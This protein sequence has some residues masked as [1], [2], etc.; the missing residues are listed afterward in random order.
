MV[1]TNRARYAMINA[2][3]V[4]PTVSFSDRV[5]SLRP[6]KKRITALSTP[7]GISTNMLLII[8]KL[9]LD[10]IG[11]AGQVKGQREHKLESDLR[12]GMI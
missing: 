1:P 7:Q 2:V 11:T 4:H 12:L 3:I 9:K 8:W 6:T 10:W 5:K